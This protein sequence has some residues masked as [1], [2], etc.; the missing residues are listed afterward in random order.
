MTRPDDDSQLTKFLRQHRSAIPPAS[1]TLEEQIMQ[2]IAGSPK[3]ETFSR[4]RSRVVSLSAWKRQVWG[5][6]SVAVA[7]SLLVVLGGYRALTPVK[8][9]TAELA[10]LEKFLEAN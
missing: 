10:T 5:T 8:P 3:A 2:T 7:A 9:T 4:S 1:V 6:A